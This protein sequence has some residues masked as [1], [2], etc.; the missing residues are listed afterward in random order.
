MRY[1][2]TPDVNREREPDGSL[3]ARQV[4][5]LEAQTQLY[6]AQVYCDR[7]AYRQRSDAHRKNYNQAVNILRDLQRQLLREYEAL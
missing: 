6:R 7:L 5:I 2:E 4:A 3:G 1:Y